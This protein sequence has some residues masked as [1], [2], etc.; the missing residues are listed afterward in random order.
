MTTYEDQEQVFKEICLGIT[1][2]Q[3][4]IMVAVS[5]LTETL[6]V[7]QT[8]VI[9]L[10]VR[11]LGSTWAGRM[12]P[13]E[14]GWYIWR[15]RSVRQLAASVQLQQPQFYITFEGRMLKYKCVFEHTECAFKCTA[16]YH[17]LYVLAL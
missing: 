7:S 6:Y 5:P 12:R 17:H 14:L 3:L 16:V 13:E 15:L 4:G 2:Y 1:W 11:S 9:S 8:I 10:S